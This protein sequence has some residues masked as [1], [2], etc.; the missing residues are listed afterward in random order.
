MARRAAPSPILVALFL[1]ATGTATAHAAT[2]TIAF[3]LSGSTI[4]ILGGAI[5]VPPDGT[6][7]SASS[8]AVFSASGLTSVLAGP[9]RL[10]SVTIDAT[11]AG[12]ITG[13]VSI[14]GSIFANQVGSALGTLTRASPISS[15]D[16]S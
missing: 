10:R 9:A 4:Q 8:T 13:S 2:V 5:T 1:L 12:T 14:T 11:L 7:V 6:I 3:D 16:P 15:S